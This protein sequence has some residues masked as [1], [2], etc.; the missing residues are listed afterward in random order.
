MSEAQYNDP[1]Q[2]R[3]FQA[4][5]DAACG[6]M[7]GEPIHLTQ[8]PRPR[9][10]VSPNELLEERRRSSD[11]KEM[12]WRDMLLVADNID[13]IFG[14]GQAEVKDMAQRGLESPNPIEPW[15][16]GKDQKDTDTIVTPNFN[17]GDALR[18]LSELRIRVEAV[19]RELHTAHVVGTQKEEN[20]LQKEVD[21]IRSKI[22]ELSG[23]LAPKPFE[24][25]E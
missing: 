19:E 25:R 21:S 6:K 11:E 9:T 16:A 14:E 15:T 17:D 23:K 1:D 18:E 24:D 7:D 10:E 3:E 22:E 5:W 20:K 2:M 8:P 12:P 4:L 13:K